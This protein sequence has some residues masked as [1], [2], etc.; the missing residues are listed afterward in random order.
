MTMTCMYD[1]DKTA[2]SALNEKVEIPVQLKSHV[3]SHDVFAKGRERQKSHTL[4]HMKQKSKCKRLSSKYHLQNLIRIYSM[5]SVMSSTS[6]I[7]G[8]TNLFV[9]RAEILLDYV[10]TY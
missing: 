4:L 2:F 8:F 5:Q 6:K 3:N 10:S 1:F 9:Y 7:V